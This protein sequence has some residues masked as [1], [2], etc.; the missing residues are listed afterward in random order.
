MKIISFDANFCKIFFNLKRQLST[1]K[2]QPVRK[3]STSKSPGSGILVNKSS[4]TPKPAPPTNGAIETLNNF[5]KIHPKDDL[6]IKKHRDESLGRTSNTSAAKKEHKKSAGKQAKKDNSPA[7]H[8]VE[9]K[10]NVSNDA[11]DAHLTIPMEV[12]ANAV[13]S[14]PKES[15]KNHANKEKFNK[16]KRNDALLVQQLGKYFSKS[17]K[18]FQNDK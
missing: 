13:P 8:T 16:K 5:D 14:V 6:E 17:L 4:V 2:M 3:T 18:F 15:P 9:K 1:G 11:V 12:V 7:A 10:S